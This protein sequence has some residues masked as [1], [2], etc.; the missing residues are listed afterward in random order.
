MRAN[1]I[2]L[3]SFTLFSMFAADSRSGPCDPSTLLQPGTDTFLNS[4]ATPKRVESVDLDKDG[5]LDLVVSQWGARKIS[6]HLGVGD[7]TFAPFVEYGVA[8]GIGVK[9]QGLA[10]ADFDGDTHLDIAVGSMDDWLVT[11]LKGDGTGSFSFSANYTTGS[12]VSPADIVAGDLDQDGDQDL[13]VSSEGNSVRV[14]VNNGDGTFASPVFEFIPP[15]VHAVAIADIN[16]DNDPDIIAIASNS[17]KLSVLYG[18]AETNFLTP[19]AFDTPN[20]PSDVQV[21]DMD[22][23]GD[24]DLVVVSLFDMISVYLNDGSGNFN[25]RT[26]YPC[27]LTPWDLKL[28]DIDND[29]DPDVVIATY[30]SNPAGIAL[31]LNDGSGGLSTQNNFGG[32]NSARGVSVGDFNEDG[33]PDVAAVYEVGNDLYVYLNAC[34]PTGGGCNLADLAMP[35]GSLDFFDVSAFLIAYSAQDPAADI[36]GDGMFNFFDVGAFLVAFNGGCP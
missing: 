26:D 35:Y 32:S 8:D 24:L 15:S 18:T 19:V 14:L 31:M 9:P 3:I 28:E 34:P 27:G 20:A 5:H 29:G 22:N 17:N 33:A 36:N 21:A 11:I 25:P 30:S 6:V 1:T 4:L 13:V 2:Y 10:V 7:G 12:F 16:N 23:D